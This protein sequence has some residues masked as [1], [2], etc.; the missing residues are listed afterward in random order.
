[1]ALKA[2]L[3]ALSSAASPAQQSQMIAMTADLVIAGL[4][5]AVSTGAAVLGSTQAIMTIIMAITVTTVLEDRRS[6]IV[7][8]GA[9]VGSV[10]AEEVPFGKQRNSRNFTK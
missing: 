10:R 9:A 7:V 1:M 5:T 3:L 2:P 6:A 4:I 8:S